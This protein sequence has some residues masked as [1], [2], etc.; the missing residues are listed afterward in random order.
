MPDHVPLPDGGLMPGLTTAL[1]SRALRIYFALAYPGGAVPPSK[2]PY[3]EASADQPLAS[4]L[5]PPVCQPVAA[6]TGGVRGYAFRLGTDTFPHLKLEVIDCGDGLCVFGVDTH[7]AICLPPGHP[8]AARWAELQAANARLKEAIE[9][10]WEAAGLL[11]FHTLL[12]EE[13]DTRSERRLK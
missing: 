3:A 12:R 4:L 11:T 7:D 8:E 13:L 2:R 1:L 6:P 5:V 10:A 9:A